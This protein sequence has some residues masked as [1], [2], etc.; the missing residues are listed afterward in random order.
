ML[1]VVVK[2]NG[3]IGDTL[4]ASS[5]AEPMK[6]ERRGGQPFQLNVVS[7]VEQPLELLKNNIWIDKVWLREYPNDLPKH[8]YYELGQVNQEI[9]VTL[10]FQKACGIKNTRLSYDIFTNSIY[11]NLAKNHLGKLRENGKPI[12]CFQANW[13]ERS[14]GLTPE[15]YERAENHPMGYG[16]RRRN[17]DLILSL[18]TKHCNLIKVGYPDST[19]VNSIGLFSAPIYSMTA[20]IIKKS[21]FF[22]GAEGGLSNL[23]GG[24]GTR[25]IL[26]W[27]FVHQVYGPKGSV[28]QIQNPQMGPATYFPERGHVHLD[29]FLSDEDV[30]AKIIEIVEKKQ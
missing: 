13:K 18:L 24:V 21:D 29:P 14:F 4:L 28:R 12:V 22:I 2:V 3:F 25:C 5:I 6:M 15:E 20:S 26:T 19:D 16:K 17:I 30:A 10:Q 23:A 8:E 9:P 1:Q 11:D 27:D 7:P